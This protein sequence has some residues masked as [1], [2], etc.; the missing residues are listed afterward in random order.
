MKGVKR[1]NVKIS[2]ND[3]N[4][5]ISEFE[6]FTIP[7]ISLNKTYSVEKDNCLYIVNIYRNNYGKLIIDIHEVV[8]GMNIKIFET[9]VKE[10]EDLYSVFYKNNDNYEIYFRIDVILE[11]KDINDISSYVLN[12]FDSVNNLYKLLNTMTY[13][14]FNNDF[15]L[16]EFCVVAIKNI[17]LLKPIVKQFINEKFNYYGYDEDFLP[18]NLTDI[19]REF[20]YIDK[21]NWEKTTSKNILNKIIKLLILEVNHGSISE[22]LTM[23]Q[24]NY[25]ISTL[26]GMYI[27]SI[28]YEYMK[29]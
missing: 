11:R 17:P 3:M 1:L 4:E 22:K 6:L 7:G 2:E 15:E 24:I 8:E 23:E 18:V 21:L 9:I 13:N 26:Y 27:Y 29:K 19:V 5:L 28:F 10:K 16:A 25:S 20:Q 12:R 14:D